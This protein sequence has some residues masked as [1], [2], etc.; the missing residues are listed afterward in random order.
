MEKSKAYD[1]P[2]RIFHWVFALLF[3]TSFLIAKLIDDESSLYAYHML[4]G[5][6]MVSIVLLRILWGIWGSKTARFGSFKLKPSEL[7]AYFVSV[8]KNNVTRY[9]GHNPASSYA[10]ILMMLFAFG[11]GTTGL[12]M[13]LKINKHFFKEVHE[14]IANGFLIV[15]L[16]H[17]SG[18]IL[19]QVRNKD[20][21]ILSMVNGKKAKT[22]S[23]SDIESN[24][25][26][27]G[28][29]LV[30]FIVAMGSFLLTH[31][32]RDTG[33][34]SAFGLHLQLGENEHE[35][36][37]ENHQK[38]SNKIG[39]H[40]DDDDDDKNNERKEDRDDHDEDQNDDL[41]DRD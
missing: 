1:L 16:L 28:V 29:F 13:S 6:L 31:F 15:V 33:K 26:F 35:E 11:L 36:H 12:L 34:L 38:H 30:G 27:V 23:E 25:V 2:V 3:V 39:S 41:E 4:S 40:D 18:V 9:L 10:A 20:G 7:I 19:H 24:H 5:I 14:L 17:I 22:N 8:H 21:M 32:E 37:G